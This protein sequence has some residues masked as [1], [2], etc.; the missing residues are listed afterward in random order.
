MV[1]LMKKSLYGL[2]KSP[3]RQYKQFDEF[4]S[5]LKFRRGSYGSCVYIRECKE[6]GEV[7]LL[8]YVDDMLLAKR[9]LTDLSEIKAQMSKEFEMKD[10]EATRKIRGMEIFRN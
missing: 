3:R 2:K 6:K 5:K 10:L 8:L 4:I 7:Y 9:D 1:C